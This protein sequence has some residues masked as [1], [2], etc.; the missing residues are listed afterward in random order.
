M[1]RAKGNGSADSYLESLQLQAL[2]GVCKGPAGQYECIG[3]SP[4][5]PG[6]ILSPSG[7][8]RR[9]RGHTPSHHDFYF[10]HQPPYILVFRSYL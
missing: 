3:A 6:D 7:R 2:V 5:F 1:S 10:P 9:W 8:N 4:N